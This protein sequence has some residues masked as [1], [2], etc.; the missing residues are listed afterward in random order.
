MASR[1]KK[2]IMA[3]VPAVKSKIVGNNTVEWVD[4]RGLIH[5]RLHLTDILTRRPDRSETYHTGG[6]N[7]VTTKARLSEFS[8]HCSF[9]SCE[10]TWY[11]SNG[12]NAVLFKDGM[13]YTPGKGFTKFGKHK[14]RLKDNRM[15]AKIRRYAKDFADA[16]PVEP[17]SGGDCWYCSMFHKDTK[18]NI[19]DDMDTLHADGSVDRQPNDEH[20]LAHM[21]EKY[22]VP[23]LLHNALK[24]SGAGQYWYWAAFGSLGMEGR[25]KAFYAKVLRKYLRVRLVDK[26]VRRK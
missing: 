2:E 22:Y 20:L 18:Q 10:G 11:V 14:D 1:T 7:T 19:G 25:D 4:E 23:F 8:K 16:L 3:G 6:W 12:T 24:E 13:R 26:R 21:R 9:Y 17:P 5:I 15:L